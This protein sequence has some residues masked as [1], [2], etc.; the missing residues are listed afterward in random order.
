MQRINSDKT[1]LFHV[2][3][4]PDYRNTVLNVKENHTEKFVFIPD[5]VQ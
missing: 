3:T 5:A 1:F 4:R 2:R